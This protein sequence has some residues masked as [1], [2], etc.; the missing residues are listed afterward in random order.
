MRETVRSPQLSG[1]RRGAAKPMRVIRRTR[2]RG[3]TQTPPR[4]GALLT[5]PL[6]EGSFPFLYATVTG[7]G[8][9]RESKPRDGHDHG[10][11]NPTA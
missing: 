11:R 6:W 9:G 3:G 5:P 7:T 8:G 10:N 1:T 2:H 4:E